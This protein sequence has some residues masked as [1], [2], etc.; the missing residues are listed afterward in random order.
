MQFRLL[1]AVVSAPRR[2][3]TRSLPTGAGTKDTRCPSKLKSRAP[4]SCWAVHCGGHADHR[5]CPG[6]QHLHAHRKALNVNDAP[7][8]ALK[9]GRSG[10]RGYPDHKAAR[11]LIPIRDWV[12]TGRTMRSLKV[13][14]A[15]E[16]QAVI[17][18]R[19]IRTRTALPTPTTSVSASSEF[20]QGSASAEHSGARG[21]EKRACGPR[22]KGCE[23]TMRRPRLSVIRI[24]PLAVE[25]PTVPHPAALDR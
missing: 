2:R 11:G 4:A 3:R 20:A 19:A 8:K 15:N 6:G 22:E 25:T 18:L 12:W 10:R 23:L 7:A 13:K 21:T 14:S 5:R 16:N 24:L 1:I 9:P 17:W